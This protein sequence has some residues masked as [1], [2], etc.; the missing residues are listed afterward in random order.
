M[1]LNAHE[2]VSLSDDD[3]SSHIFKAGAR[4]PLQPRAR[5]LTRPPE[6]KAR[7]SFSPSG[8]R[9]ATGLVTMGL[10]KLQTSSPE[11]LSKD[12]KPKS[13]VQA[14]AEPTE[15]TAHTGV[16]QPG[17]DGRAVMK[18]SKKPGTI[19]GEDEHHA[20]YDLDRARGTSSLSIKVDRSQQSMRLGMKRNREE[21]LDSSV[22]LSKRRK[23]DLRHS[24]SRFSSRSSLPAQRL[25][26]SSPPRSQPG[27]IDLTMDSPRRDAFIDLTVDDD[28][29]IDESGT[30]SKGRANESTE[31]VQRSR[32]EAIVEEVRKSLTKSSLSSKGLTASASP[33]IRNG[34]LSPFS[35]SHRTKDPEIMLGPTE[36][37][38]ER[39]GETQFARQAHKSTKEQTTKPSAAEAPVLN[40]SKLASSNVPAAK[41]RPASAVMVRAKSPGTKKDNAYESR[42]M[43]DRV[44]SAHS[45]GED[46]TQSVRRELSE[47]VQQGTKRNLTKQTRLKTADQ[48]ALD[49]V[50][51]LGSNATGSA[52]NKAEAQI[53]DEMERAAA[54]PA[55][56]LPLPIASLGLSKQVEVVL[57]G[58][59]EESRGD[60]EYFNRAQL[61]RARMSLQTNSR[62]GDTGLETSNRPAVPYAFTKMQPMKLATMD[63]DNSRNGSGF[64]R[65]QFERTASGP[66]KAQKISLTCPTTTFT[67]PAD[68]PGYAHFVPIKDN[69]LAPNITTMQ[70]WPYFGDGF[71]YST[72]GGLGE[73]YSLDIRDREKKLRRLLQAQKLDEYVANA[74]QDLSITWADVLRFLLEIK[75]SIGDDED[76]KKA[77]A[78]REEFCQEE[79]SRKGERTAM[80]LSILPPSTIDQLAKAATLCENFRRMTKF[81]LWHVARRHL[82]DNK[83]EEESLNPANRLDE[84]TCRICFRLE[85]PHHGEITERQDDDCEDPDEGADHAIQTDIV[86]P[87]KVNYRERIAF[88]SAPGT[89]SSEQDVAVVS[90]KKSLQYWRS[91]TFVHKIEERGPFYGCH[92]PGS[93]CS[94][95]NCACFE[96]N[97]P[98]EKICTCSPAD[99]SRKF[100]GCICKYRNKRK[101]QNIVCFEDDRCICFNLGRECDP[102]LCGECGV[103]EVLDPLNRLDNAFCKGKCQNA[104]I[105]RGVPKQTLIG[106]SGIHGLG[107]YAGENIKAHD[108]IGEYKGEIITKEEAE[109][110]GAVYEH[111]KLS[112]LFVLNASQEIDSTY[113]GNDIRFINHAHS[114]NAA[115]NLYPRIFLVN[116]VHRIALFAEKDIKAG[117]ELLFDYG[118]KFPDSQ[119]GGQGNARGRNTKKDLYDVAETVNKKGQVRATKATDVRSAKAR[120]AGAESNASPSGQG[121][122]GGARPNA[123]RKPSRKSVMGVE[124]EVATQR[125]ASPTPQS[126]DHRRPPE[127][128]LAIYY[129]A[130][131]EPEEGM[132]DNINMTDGVQEEDEDASEFE[133]GQDEQDELSSPLASESVP[134]SPEERRAGMRIRGRRHALRS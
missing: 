120:K 45:D 31:R 17:D 9:N 58:Y 107:L 82:F 66:A 110:R 133:E 51:D 78:R 98:C 55:T 131:N 41:V 43:Q 24:N 27:E 36:N 50:S 38:N 30:G 48:N 73:Q 105:Q 12:W 60:N 4:G 47:D 32:R 63:K 1:S 111:Q 106:V 99:C 114:G 28:L 109:R 67:F 18:N 77:L 83:P 103:D 116:A 44:D 22:T 25:R 119:L 6:S 26:A 85:C 68:M 124:P 79:F 102:D 21:N 20:L 74:L 3:S 46:S 40:K 117:K 100:Q 90:G 64:A 53:T 34:T 42:V 132:A 128:R 118:P 11:K 5:F 7:H 14:L 91:E 108:F 88:P 72:A 56:S 76:A 92:H 69:F 86:H 96:S 84:L 62:N 59:L 19:M 126:E 52:T 8:R 29:A 97:I 113:F 49:T 13:G 130:E 87:L 61:R 94:D 101:G 123:G 122:R 65:F 35:V 93:S 104:S 81:D 16:A 71:D 89:T 37:A 125:P 15:R 95:N 75:P 23:Q 112:Y 115:L 57:G 10:E 129:M 80:V 134:S 127:D 39:L 70:H 121:K 54:A 2:V 33:R